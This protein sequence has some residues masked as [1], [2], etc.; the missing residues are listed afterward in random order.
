MDTINAIKAARTFVA[1]A[2]STGDAIALLHALDGDPEDAPVG[3]PAPTPVKLRRARPGK[4]KA[5]KGDGR[6]RASAADVEARKAAVLRVFTDAPKESVFAKTDVE[7]K[8]GEE[9]NSHTLGL[10]VKDGKLIMTGERRAAR[11]RLA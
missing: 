2:G 4:Q 5:P 9:V 3:A 8:L 7:A 11:Y 6:Q 10:L 1:A